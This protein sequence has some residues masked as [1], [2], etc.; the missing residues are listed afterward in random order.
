MEEPQPSATHWRPEDIAAA[1]HDEGTISA[2]E[3]LRLAGEA[4][5]AI[6]DRSRSLVDTLEGFEKEEEAYRVVAGDAIQKVGE[7]RVIA[8]FT[9][10]WMAPSPDNLQRKFT[11]K[12][13]EHVILA[14]RD[15]TEPPTLEQ[16]RALA[17]MLDDAGTPDNGKAPHLR[18]SQVKEKKPREPKEKKPRAKKKAEATQPAAQAA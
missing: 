8:G 14:L 13:V 16:L 5:A 6:R 15:M 10:E 2:G 3:A 9:Y 7:T 18:I 12:V 1:F 4:I 11:P 17:K